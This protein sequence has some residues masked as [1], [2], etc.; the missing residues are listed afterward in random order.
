MLGVLFKR[1][2]AL[3][4][5]EAVVARCL[6]GCYP[7]LGGPWIPAFAGKTMRKIGASSGPL[8]AFPAPPCSPSF[9]PRKRGPRGRGGAVATER[10]SRSEERRVGQGGRGEWGACG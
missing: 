1:R 9:P 5:A 4:R 10:T 3:C 2:H 8:R 7:V 6:S